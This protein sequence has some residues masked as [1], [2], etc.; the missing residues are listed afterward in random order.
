ME[1]HSELTFV[2]V[3]P[4]SVFHHLVGPLSKLTQ[5]ILKWMGGGTH[6]FQSLRTY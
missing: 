5:A 2:V 4:G 1:S 6:P 3:R